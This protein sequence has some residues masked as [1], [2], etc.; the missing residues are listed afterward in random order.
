[1]TQSWWASIGA[2]CAPQPHRSSEFWVQRPSIQNVLVQQTQGCCALTRTGQLLDKKRSPGMYSLLHQLRILHQIFTSLS[3]A[4]WIT[5]YSTKS[6][7]YSNRKFDTFSTSKNAWQVTAC[8]QHSPGNTSVPEFLESQAHNTED[9]AMP[10]PSPGTC[11][12]L[13]HW[14]P[15]PFCLFIYLFISADIPVFST[16]CPLR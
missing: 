8:R 2:S 13:R 1:M 7:I 3:L 15:S 4:Q 12:I 5:P 16:P 10:A 14:C 9:K 6:N 11:V